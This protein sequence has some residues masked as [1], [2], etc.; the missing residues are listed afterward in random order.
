MWGSEGPEKPLPPQTMQWPAVEE[1]RAKRAH[2]HAHTV[3]SHHLGPCDNLCRQGHRYH[4]HE[5]LTTAVRN[6]AAR[7]AMIRARQLQEARGLVDLEPVNPFHYPETISGGYVPRRRDALG[8]P[9]PDVDP[10]TGLPLNEQS[11]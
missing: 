8:N 3:P 6:E 4:I 5:R 9:L 10:V 7:H 11:V 2:A 1:E